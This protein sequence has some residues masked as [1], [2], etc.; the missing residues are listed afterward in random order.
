MEVAI[1]LSVMTQF[2]SGSA[3]VA[4][5][6]DGYGAAA[7]Q[8]ISITDGGRVQGEYSDGRSMVLGQLAIAD[9]ANAEGLK[10]SGSNLFSPSAASGIPL[11]GAAGE[12]GRGDVVGQTLESSNTDLTSSFL[13]ML[14]TQRAY[15]ASTRVIST[16]NSML[17]ETINLAR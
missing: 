16:A 6:Q 9:F 2:S 8:S 17:E 14:I 4:T 13:D 11:V 15:Q 5:S 10:R 7:L 3:P 12:D 1:D